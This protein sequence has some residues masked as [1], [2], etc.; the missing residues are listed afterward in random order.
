MQRTEDSFYKLAFELIAHGFTTLPG[1]NLYVRKL[2]GLDENS[3]DK[4]DI[5]HD[6]N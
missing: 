3:P 6:N 5:K 4:Q 1:I 2:A